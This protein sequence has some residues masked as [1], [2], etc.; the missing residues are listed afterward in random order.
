MPVSPACM[1]GHL[2]PTIIRS[3]H[4]N[5]HKDEHRVYN[6]P[7]ATMSKDAQKVH[8]ATQMLEHIT[9]FNI[10]ELNYPANRITVSSQVCAADL[11]DRIRIASY[12]SVL[13]ASSFT[14]Y[15]RA[16]LQIWNEK[17]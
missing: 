1:S 14:S 11:L 6:Q 17:K 4:A 3:S 7:R 5:S 8:P 12:D 13:L 15:V 10:F 2:Y 9:S 16:D